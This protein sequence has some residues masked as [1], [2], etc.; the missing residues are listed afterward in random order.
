MHSG[1]FITKGTKVSVC[2][3]PQPSPP[4]CLQKRLDFAYSFPSSSSTEGSS[5]GDAELGDYMKGKK[6]QRKSHFL[7]NPKQSV[8]MRR[9]GYPEGQQRLNGVDDEG[10]GS[11]E[12][13]EMLQRL[14]R[15]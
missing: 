9:G 15:T 10:G 12:K 7:V 6:A 11:T 13:D 5:T 2:E 4:L 8:A 1:L 3:Y 14:L